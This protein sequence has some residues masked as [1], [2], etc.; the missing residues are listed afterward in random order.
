MSRA[1]CRNDAIQATTLK[2][3]FGGFLDKLLYNMSEL[4]LLSAMSGPERAH[5]DFE[6]W[7]LWSPKVD[8]S[9]SK[10][11]DSRPTWLFALQLTRY[12]TWLDLKGWVL[13]VIDWGPLCF[14]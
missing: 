6:S 8:Q 2:M 4:W 12:L 1:F 10:K 7:L 11:T 14:N 5:S 9:Q 3:I 13:L